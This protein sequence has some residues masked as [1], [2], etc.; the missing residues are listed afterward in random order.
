M[1][2]IPG[3]SIIIEVMIPTGSLE[4]PEIG[5]QYPFRQVNPS[6]QSPSSSQILTHSP[7]THW[8]PSGQSPS[9]VQTR[10]HL[11]STHLYPSGQL[12]SSLQGIVPSTISSSSPGIY[13]SP[14]STTMTPSIDPPLPPGPGGVIVVLTIDPLPQPVLSTT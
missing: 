8:Y 10:T 12:E 6:G 3:P 7:S 1:Y 14:G 13:P 5:T 2:P 9:S 11:P 4:I